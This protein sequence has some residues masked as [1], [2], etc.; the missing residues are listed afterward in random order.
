MPLLPEYV[1]KEEVNRIQIPRAL[2]WQTD[3]TMKSNLKSKQGLD[4]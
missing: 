3:R 2:P 4:V 1:F